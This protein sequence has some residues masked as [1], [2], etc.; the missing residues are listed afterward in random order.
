MKNVRTYGLLICVAVTVFL[1]ACG[2]DSESGNAI[3]TSDS[4]EAI[5]SGASDTGDTFDGGVALPFDMSAL[6][7]ADEIAMDPAQTEMLQESNAR[8]IGDMSI[9]DTSDLTGV[10]IPAIFD[11]QTGVD[12]AFAQSGAALV[13]QLNE[14]LLLP[15]NVNVVFADCGVA[16]AFYI[17]AGF[18]PGAQ[19]GVA[20]DIVMCHE[21]TALFANFFGNNEQAFLTSTFVLMHELGHALVDVLT[22]P[23]LGIEESY[24]DGIASVLLGE[25]GLSEGSVLAG[26]FF[27]S[28]PGTPFFDSHRA[29]PQRL[30][31]LACWGVGADISLLSDPLTNSIAS[32]LFAGGR[33]CVREYQQQVNGFSTVLGPSILGGLDLL[34]SQ[35]AGS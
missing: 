21:L 16:N 28:Q 12:L 31:D 7:P 4:S 8:P 35:E 10:L 3:D 32:Q 23:V 26:W 11:T 33:N 25:S 6:D 27:G 30:G 14:S 5:E 20:G 2:S 9:I 13:E 18:N 22:L 29:G 19:Q 34:S 17:P 15:E 24:V 1:N